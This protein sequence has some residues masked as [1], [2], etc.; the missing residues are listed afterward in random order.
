MSDD[1]VVTG[2]GALTPLG[3]D[4]E[5]LWE[6]LLQ[7]RSG[8][9]RIDDLLPAGGVLDE[10]PVRI[11]ATMAVSPDTL[12]SRVQARRMDRCEQAALVAAQQAWQDAG[13]PEVDQERLA[14]VIG[15][16]IGGVSTLLAQD[17]LLE[18]KGPGKVSPLTVPM[19]MPN[20]PA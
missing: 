4:V 6:G 7:G 1:V 16:G 9:R 20:G 11:G 10:L 3:G 5:S 15:T 14:V 18:A 2:M 12:L 8:V 13:A 17:D 19:L